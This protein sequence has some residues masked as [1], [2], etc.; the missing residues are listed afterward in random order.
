M[1]RAVN[2]IS[3]K[4]IY[5][6]LS[7]TQK[8]FGRFQFGISFPLIRITSAQ[9]NRMDTK[10]TPKTRKKKATAESRKKP[11]INKIHLEPLPGWNDKRVAYIPQVKRERSEATIYYNS[12][13]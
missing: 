10:K 5:V 1:V 13:S 7:S 2:N 4:L 3:Y 8:Q 6:F 9:N 12:A 11:R